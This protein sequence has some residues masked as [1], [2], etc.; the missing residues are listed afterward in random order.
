MTENRD[1]I[2]SIA[3]DF[4]LFTMGDRFVA[5]PP[6]HHCHILFDPVI[7]L[8]R[9][10]LDHCL[11]LVVN[12]CAAALSVIKSGLLSAL[13]LTMLAVPASAQQRTQVIR[14]P[15]TSQNLLAMADVMG[16]MHYLNVLCKGKQNQDWR[17]RMV[18]MLELENPEYYLR[19]QLISSFNNGFRQQ[20]RMFGVCSER[21]AAQMQQKSKQGRILSDALGDPY[22]Q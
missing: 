7:R 4:L 18:E 12:P 2:R 9:T 6:R 16:A 3:A 21:I 8:D 11:R 10:V 17:E 22:L 20:Q 1:G 19:A 5:R 13:L 15:E 14:P